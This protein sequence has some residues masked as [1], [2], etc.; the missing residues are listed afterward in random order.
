M[1]IFVHDVSPESPAA[2]HNGLHCGD[3]ILEVGI[4]EHI[5]FSFCLF[6]FRK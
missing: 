3:Q 4:N 5:Y 1:G 6:F 2:G